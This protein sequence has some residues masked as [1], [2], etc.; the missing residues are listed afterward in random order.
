MISGEG[1][2]RVVVLDKEYKKVSE[3][4]ENWPVRAE[5]KTGRIFASL[6]PGQVSLTSENSNFVN[7]YC[8]V[9]KGFKWMIISCLLVIGHFL[10]IRKRGKLKRHLVDLGLV[11]VTGIFGFIAVNIFPNKF[12]D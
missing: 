5:T 11:L 10:I 8:T 2:V 12:F 7:F 1:F 3:Y 9:S 4:N 6:F